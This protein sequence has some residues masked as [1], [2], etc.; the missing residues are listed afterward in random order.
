MMAL[1]FLMK[2]PKS[3]WWD[4]YVWKFS[5]DGTYIDARPVAWMRLPEYEGGEQDD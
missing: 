2:F 5:P 1:D 4:G 3:L